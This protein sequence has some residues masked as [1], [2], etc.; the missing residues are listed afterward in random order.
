MNHPIISFTAVY[1]KAPHGYVGF[2]EELPGVNSH[3]QTIEE[4]R[5][6]LQS[7]AIVIFDLE[8]TQAKEMLEGKDVV[9]ESFTLMV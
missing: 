3:G 4:A 1:L 2:I 9:R 6:N 7:L 8:R 5:A